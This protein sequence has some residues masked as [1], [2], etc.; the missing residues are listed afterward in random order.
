MRDLLVVW[1]FAA[2]GEEIGYRGYLVARAADLGNRS[3]LAY[4]VAIVYVG[5]L[6]GIGHFYKGAAGVID[7]TY[8]GLVLGGVYLLAGKNLWAPILAHGIC[9]TIAVGAVF[10]GWAN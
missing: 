6:F 8:S 1:T 10:M 5:L 9:D 3:R 4:A 2:F 7:S